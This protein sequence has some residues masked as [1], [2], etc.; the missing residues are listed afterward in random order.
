M[1]VPPV[2]ATLFR[3]KPVGTGFDPV[4]APLK[5]NDAL[6]PVASGAL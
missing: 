3:V 6:P 4:Q 2:Q 5:P 1:V